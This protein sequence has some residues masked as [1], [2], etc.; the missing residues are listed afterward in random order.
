MKFHTN[1]LCYFLVNCKMAANEAIEIVN[2]V[3]LLQTKHTR[4]WLLKL[5]FAS[6]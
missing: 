3:F 1:R 4:Q 2:T 5:V 6:T